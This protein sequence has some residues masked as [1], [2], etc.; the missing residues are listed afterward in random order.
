[1][2][3]QTQFKRT[4][5][6]FVMI[7]ALPALALAGKGNGDIHGKKKNRPGTEPQEPAVTAVDSAV[8]DNGGYPNAVVT[9]SQGRPC[10]AYFV[11]K[12]L[13]FAVREGS[14]WNI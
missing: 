9:D 2:A 14:I 3:N 11:G 1:M 7:A 4:L 10:V 5:A 12:E 6:I 13:V 8:I